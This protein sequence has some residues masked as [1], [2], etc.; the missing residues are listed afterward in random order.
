ML[1]TRAQY[2]RM[3]YGKCI[4]PGYRHEWCGEDVLL[5]LE[6]ICSGKRNCE[7]RIPDKLLESKAECPPDLKTYLNVS[8]RC[9]EGAWSS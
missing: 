7:I 6:N 9:V 5:Q 8:Y 4:K 3:E 2:G 1:I